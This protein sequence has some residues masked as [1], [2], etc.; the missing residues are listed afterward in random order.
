LQER[1]D[2][3]SERDLAGSGRRLLR[4]GGYR[5]KDGRE[6]RQREAHADLLD[7]RNNP[8]QGYTFLWRTLLPSSCEER[9]G[10]IDA[11]PCRCCGGGGC[12]D[13]SVRRARTGR[14]EEHTSE[15]QSRGH[16]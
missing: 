1:R 12:A 7:G 16:L 5:Q 9:H 13:G 8:L 3:S 4:G 6:N 14:S 11:H 10:C 15:L 2:V